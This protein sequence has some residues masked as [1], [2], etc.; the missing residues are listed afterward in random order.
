LVAVETPFTLQHQSM[1][2]QMIGVHSPVHERRRHGIA[3]SKILPRV[4]LCQFHVA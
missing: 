4:E 1:Q 3:S 2:S